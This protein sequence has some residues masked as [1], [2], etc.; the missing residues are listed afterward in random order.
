MEL[1][2][3]PL[4]AVTLPNF[5]EISRNVIAKHLQLKMIENEKS[6]RRDA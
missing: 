3:S 4:V 5:I 6:E 1:G 2:I